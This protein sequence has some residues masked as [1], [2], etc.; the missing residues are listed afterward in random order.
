ML[1]ESGP[2]GNWPC[3]LSVAS[4]TPYRS[5]TTQHLVVAWEVMG[6][7]LLSPS[8]VSWLPISCTFRCYCVDDTTINIW[9]AYFYVSGRAAWHASLHAA[10]SPPVP[11]SHDTCESFRW[12]RRQTCWVRRT[13]P[14][15]GTRWSRK[16]TT[17]Y[18][19]FAATADIATKSQTA[20]TR[21]RTVGNSKPTPIDSRGGTVFIAVCLCVCLSA[22]YCKNR[23]SHDHQTWHTDVPRWVLDTHLFWGQT[24]KGQGH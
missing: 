23:C 9:S 22:R 17:R 6:E 18:G 7:N 12:R 1:C 16:G 5:A 11:D 14:A 2:A 13:R 21:S 24:I 20:N 15:A 10:P 8:H 19:F 4:T 3:D